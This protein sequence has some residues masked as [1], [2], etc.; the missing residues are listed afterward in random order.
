VTGTKG[1]AGPRGELWRLIGGSILALAPIVFGAYWGIREARVIPTSAISPSE[2]FRF[3]AEVLSSAYEPYFHPDGDG[4]RHARRSGTRLYEGERRLGPPHRPHEF[5]QTDGLGQF[6]HWGATLSFSSS[7]NS[8]PRTN[9]RIYRVST[10]AT[11]SSAVTSFWS[12]CLA[13]TAGLACWLRRTG[14]TSSQGSPRTWFVLGLA[15]TVATYYLLVRFSSDSE[16]AGSLTRARLLLLWAAS[17]GVSLLVAWQ[18]GVLLTDFGQDSVRSIGRSW[19]ALFSRANQPFTRAGWSG[20]L[21]RASSLAVP[22]LVFA[23]VLRAPLPNSILIASYFFATP[24]VVPFGLALW[25]CFL[26]RDW[27]GTIAALTVTMALFA[28]PLAALWWHIGSHY[29]AIGGLLPFSDASGYYYDARR[30]LEGHRFGWSSRRPLYAGSLATLLALTGQNLQITLAV[31]VALNAVAASLLAREL[32]HSHGPAAAVVATMVLFLFYRIEGGLGTTLTEN[33][34][35]AMGTIGFAALWRGSRIKD[36]FGVSVGLGLLTIALMARAGAFFVLP[37]IVLAVVVAFRE[38]RRWLKAGI[39]ACAAVALSAALTL[40]VSRL[41]SDP[42]GDQTAFSNFS[43]S[44][45]GLVVGGK[46]WNQVLV[47]HP[48]AAEGA[49]I[50]TLAWQ[51]FLARPMGI[52]EGSLKMLNTYFNPAGPFHMLA[53][54]HDGSFRPWLQM[55]CYG[56]CAVGLITAARKWRDA[57]NTVALAALLGHIASIP[58]VPPIDAGLRVYAA[59][60]PIL[61]VL[62]SIGTAELLRGLRR[63][64]RIVRLPVQP[65]WSRESD[66]AAGGR[67]S[68]VVGIAIAALVLAGPLVILSVSRSPNLPSPRCVDGNAGAVVRLSAGSFLR[69]GSDLTDLDGTGLRVPDVR[70]NEIRASAKATELKNDVERFTAGQTMANLYDLKTGRLVW[71]VAPTNGAVSLSPGLFQV[72]GHASPD[73]LSKSYAVFYAQSASRVVPGEGSR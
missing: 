57:P 34:G 4:L 17:F 44:L 56:L 48:R 33:L 39:T 29:N 67:L 1:L 16:L 3:T 23:I 13:A 26:R 19:A 60:V 53:F 71:L 43:Y 58:F 54:V 31:F 61:A 15:A 69:I 10:A 21:L 63:L 49:Q 45:Y 64:A 40:V 52:V 20:V 22:L 28:L 14:G 47:D 73:P 41:L 37:A 42:S 68:A 32:R 59:T 38:N 8:D 51:A 65:H 66:A 24:V 9:G 30:L 35:L 18:V 70:R 2:G 12:L 5:I 72:C 11:L 55:L 27:L 36:L 50:Y 7:D 6:S 46:G 25:C 62:V